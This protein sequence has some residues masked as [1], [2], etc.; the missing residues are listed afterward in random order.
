M[1]S[2]EKRYNERV[3]MEDPEVT[4]GQA[5]TRG[6]SCCLGD[7][8]KSLRELRRALGRLLKRVT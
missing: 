5:G 1:T 8:W 2:E 6:R 7:R 3:T 4:Y